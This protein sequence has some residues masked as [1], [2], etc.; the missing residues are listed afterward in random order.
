MIAVSDLQL[1]DELS[2]GK[3]DLTY[4]RYVLWHI[5]FLCTD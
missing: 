5:D 1:V 3:V 4:G 2:D